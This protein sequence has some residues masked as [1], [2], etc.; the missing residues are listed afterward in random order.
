MCIIGRIVNV[1]F[2]VCD[3]KNTDY[4]Y[5]KI[6]ELKM[7]KTQLFQE[8]YIRTI[9]HAIYNIN[10]SLIKLE[11]EQGSIKKKYIIIIY[12]L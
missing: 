11:K 9:N 10:S 5:D 8:T 7:S 12:T 4:F 6:R 1:L 2:E 3:K